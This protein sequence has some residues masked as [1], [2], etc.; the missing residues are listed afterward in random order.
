MCDVILNLVVVI[1]FYRVLDSSVSPCN[2]VVLYAGGSDVLL[3]G[4]Q[5]VPTGSYKHEKCPTNCGC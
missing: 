2:S 1:M 3:C 5:E 4:R